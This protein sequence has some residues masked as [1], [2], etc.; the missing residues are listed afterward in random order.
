MAALP[1]RSDGI[2]AWPPFPA[3]C[4]VCMTGPTGCLFSPRC[5]YANDSLCQTR[6]ACIRCKT[7][8]CAATTPLVMHIQTAFQQRQ[9]PRRWQHERTVNTPSPA[10]QPVVVATNLRQCTNQP[11]S[12]SQAR[13][14][15]GR[16][17]CERSRCTLAKPWPWWVNRVVASPRWPAWSLIESPSAGNL[18]L[19]GVDVVTASHKER[20]ALR[21]TVQLVFQNPYGSFNPRKKIGAILEAPA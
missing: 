2:R 5:S 9:P 12:V 19:G 20:H 6:P 1:E 3:W 15:A 7:A 13:P 11:G 4:L 14:V 16:Q 8:S 10:D 18:K 21:R 17:R